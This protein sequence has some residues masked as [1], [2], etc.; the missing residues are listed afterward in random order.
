MSRKL[1]F[2]NAL[3]YTLT[4]VINKAIPFLLL[5]I[6][7]HYLSPADYGIVA[8]YAAFIA[9]L[10]VFIFVNMDNALN[11]AFY[12]ISFSEL[13]IYNANVIMIALGISIS[14]AII[15]LTFYGQI[16]KLVP[17]QMFWLLFG[18]GVVFMQ[19]IIGINLV[20]W[21]AEQKALP[22]GL[23]QIAQTILNLSLIL[24]LVILSDLTWKGQI[25]GQ[26]LAIFIFAI[27]AFYLLLKR[28]Y[29]KF[30]MNAE[31]MKDALKF[32]I[33]LIPLSLA[34]WF[35]TGVDRFFLMNFI[36]ASATGLYVVG[37]QFGMIIGILSAAFNKAYNQYLYK[38]LQSNITDNEKQKLVYFTYLFFITILVLALLLSLI[39][40]WIINTF[41]DSSYLASTEYVPWITFAFAFQSMYIMIVNYIY[42]IKKTKYLAYISFLAGIIHVILS[43]IL[44]KEN[45]SI[46][47]AQASL[48]SFLL[49]FVSV[50]YLS[51]KVYPM[52]WFNIMKKG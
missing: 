40:P 39:S 32:G 41:L 5:P 3:I 35:R 27:I 46:G 13:R 49:M 9:I 24:F 21:Q 22:Y 36:G 7:T 31:D 2:K 23:F 6:L 28:K 48:F 10:S 12:K 50:W 34:G 38:K 26:G 17:L 8:L 37:F 1:L 15:I 16:Y 4:D 52:P 51:A 20:L 45:G 29:L 44:I 25:I 30:D 33:P 14:I 18:V 47:A 11:I 42:F 43:Y 19:F